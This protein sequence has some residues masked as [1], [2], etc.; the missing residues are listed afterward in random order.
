MNQIIPA[1]FNMVINLAM[2]LFFIR[3]FL[4]FAEIKRFDPFAMPFY[5]ITSVVDAFKNIMPD[6][7]KGRFSTASAVL[8]LLIYLID[9]K[10]N[11]FFSGH[12]ITAIQLFFVASLGLVLKFLSVCRWI[13]F[14]MVIVSWIIMLTQNMHPIF[15]IIMQMAEPIIAPFRRISPDLGMIDISP[16]FALFGIYIAEI[17]IS[18]AM[19]SLI[20]ML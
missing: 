11:T 5:K 20:T 18:G 10:A 17:M 12:S 2:M 3:F 9:I 6:L 7:A 15:N 8:L 1:L 19:Q 14:G 16:I 13:I 4:Q